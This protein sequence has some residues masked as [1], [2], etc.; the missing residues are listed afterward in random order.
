[1]LLDSTHNSNN[2]KLIEFHT[3]K[4]RTGDIFAGDEKALNLALVHLQKQQLLTI[5]TGSNGEKVI[6]IIYN[7]VMLSG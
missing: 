1:M 2:S 6:I 3:L 7:N 5:A 4:R